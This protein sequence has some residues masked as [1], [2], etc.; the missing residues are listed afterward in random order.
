MFS[1]ENERVEFCKHF[2]PRG[3]VENWLLEVE[4]VMKK[5]VKEVLRAAVAAYPITPRPQWVLEWPGQVILTASQIYPLE[6]SSDVYLI[7]NYLLDSRCNS[8]HR[9]GQGGNGETLRSTIASVRRA[10]EVGAG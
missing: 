2:Y 6:Y 7:T 1:S 3:N 8:S 10:N 5:S 9:K 4:S